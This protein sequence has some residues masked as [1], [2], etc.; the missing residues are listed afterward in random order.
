[1]IMT[2]NSSSNISR[3]SKIAAF[4]LLLLM[5]FGLVQAQDFK[6][7]QKRLDKMVEKD[8]ISGE[9]ADAMM[10]ALKKA[11]ANDLKDEKQSANKPMREEEVRAMAEEIEAAVA[12]GKLTP[13]QGR[14]KHEAVR[15]KF[16]KSRKQNK[17]RIKERFRER[18]NGREMEMKKARYM[19]TA[20]K[21][22]A[23][24]K[25]GKVSEEDAENK[26]IKM[27][28]QMFDGD[29]KKDQPAGMMRRLEMA[30][31]S[32]RITQEQA[33]ERARAYERQLREKRFEQAATEI[34]EA[35]EA[36]KVSREDAEKR[37]SQVRER[38]ARAG[39][40]HGNQQ[41]QDVLNFLGRR[42]REA[43]AAG[44]LTRE[45]AKMMFD[46]VS[47][48]QESSD[49]NHDGHDHDHGEHSHDHDEHSRDHDEDGHDEHDRN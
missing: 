34:R 23:A 6:K 49:H 24:V 39:K 26:L 8:L 37:L 48:S 36:G 33:E 47:S 44:E 43:I 16:A 4:G 35:V 12:A 15:E 25:A 3:L 21:I 41:E 14:E 28:E 38:M 27:R 45:Q 40:G 9:Q 46:A 30:A 29:E 7:V 18:P 31:E 42:L 19:E 13:E 20:E 10:L 5:P 22:K 17:E 32:G 11:S 2:Q 1:M